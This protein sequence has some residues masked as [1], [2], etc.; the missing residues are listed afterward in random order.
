MPI[1]KI[2][3]L[4][5]ITVIPFFVSAQAPIGEYDINGNYKP[6]PNAP[7]YYYQ[8]PRYPQQAFPP[9]TP[10]A[11]APTTAPQAKDPINYLTNPLNQKSPNETNKALQ[12]V[13]CERNTL[14]IWIEGSFHTAGQVWVC[15]YSDAT[16]PHT[17]YVPEYYSDDTIKFYYQDLTRTGGKGMFFNPK[18]NTL[19]PPPAST[20]FHTQILAREITKGAVLL[21]DGK[22]LP[23]NVLS[24]QRKGGEPWMSG[25]TYGLGKSTFKLPLGVV[26][27]ENKPIAGS[28]GISFS[29]LAPE[30][31]A[32]RIPVAPIPN[33]GGLGSSPTQ[34]PSDI[35]D[36]NI[37]FA[38]S[39]SIHINLLTINWKSGPPDPMVSSDGKAFI[40][41]MG[42]K[43]VPF[44]VIITDANKDHAYEAHIVLFE[45]LESEKNKE[46]YL[47]D[48]SKIR[49]V[50]EFATYDDF[51]QYVNALPKP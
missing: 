26:T 40:F 35:F 7:A 49:F 43:S 45:F 34:T 36:R 10:V 24:L 51:I 31:P 25:N 9:T 32:A 38:G 4:F 17:F 29:L 2:I 3:A 8:Q 50:K 44:A 33:N 27:Q 16:G 42:F 30:A 13:R 19:T 48:W 1:Q 39:F 28:N 5:A 23:P 15:T 22:P 12:P 18:T 20:I 46:D 11:P 47:K 6:K 41:P 37:P 14:P 21:P